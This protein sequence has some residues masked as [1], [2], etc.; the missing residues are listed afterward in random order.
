M[1]GTLIDTVVK[2]LRSAPVVIENNVS[3]AILETE[4][5]DLVNTALPAVVVHIEN[6]EN[7]DVS[8][9]GLICD[10]VKLHLSVIASLDNPSL[11]PD[12]NIQINAL[13]LSTRIRNYIE[14]A[15][16]SKLFSEL[17]EKANFNAL[18]KGFNAYQSEAFRRDAEINVMVYDLSWQCTLL[19]L[20]QLNDPC[21]NSTAEVKEISLKDKTDNTG[22]R[23]TVLKKKKTI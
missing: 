21:I 17:V 16:R 2:A 14:A 1:I 22:V 11:S 6:S 18:Y 7:A 13:N 4:G 10:H 12:N 3:V 9:G 23:N 5:R 20:D 8:I 19:N 15:K